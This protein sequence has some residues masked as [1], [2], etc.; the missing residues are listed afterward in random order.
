MPFQRILIS[1]DS[2]EYSMLAAKRGLELAHALNAKAAL[3]FVVD[4]TK[5]MGNIDGG[6]SPEQALILLKKEAEQMLDEFAAMYNGNDLM[7]FMPEGH[8]FDT[9]H[10]TA[11]TWNADLIVMGTHGRKG[12]QHLFAG[13]VAEHVVRH[14]NVPVM[15]VPSSDNA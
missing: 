10:V 6:V 15:I 11:H 12:L 5:A 8:P 14:S 13:S 9:I 1:V 2:S 3:L 4:T 7:K